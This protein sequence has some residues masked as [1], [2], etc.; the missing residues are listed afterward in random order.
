[1]LNF[2]RLKIEENIESNVKNYCKRVYLSISSP[3]IP[4]ESNQNYSAEI[5]P[6]ETYHIPNELNFNREFNRL[7]GLR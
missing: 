1:M 7:S 4:P 2:C 6:T 5:P 3:K